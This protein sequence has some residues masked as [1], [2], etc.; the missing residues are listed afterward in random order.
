MKDNLLYGFML[1]I[2]TFMASC[3]GMDDTYK[4]F[5]KDG[6]IVYIG[7]ADSLKAHPGHE[8]IMLTWQMQ[9]DPRGTE[10]VIYWKNRQDSI[11]FSLD[12]S[13]IKQECIIENLPE[14]SY[15]FEII[16]HD[17]YGYSSLPVE[18]SSQTY[19]DVYASYLSPRSYTKKS[20]KAVYFNNDTQK[21]EMVI[22]A[23]RD[24]T[25]IDTEVVYKDENGKDI[26]LSWKEDTKHTFTLEGYR[27]GNMV[28]YRSCFQPVPEAIDVFWTDYTY[29]EGEE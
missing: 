18:I 29:F 5:I 11:L 23:I 21:W 19:G 8:R 28:K 13:K 1:I 14:S 9:N 10:A 22:N 2:A 12:R 7:K 25:L 6:P 20:G 27:E 17:K 26:T 16:I 4:D 24:E 3:E 15:I